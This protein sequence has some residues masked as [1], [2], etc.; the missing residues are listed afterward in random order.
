MHT[1]SELLVDLYSK[2]EDKANSH[3][4]NKIIEVTG[5][6]KEI[7]FLNNRNTILLKGNTTKSSVICDMQLNQ[8]AILRKLKKDDVVKIKGVCK[9][10]LKDVILLNCTFI[11]QNTNE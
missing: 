8:T 9:G 7:S 4:K 5:I 11:N 1:N 3:Y 10:Y 6:V 2:D